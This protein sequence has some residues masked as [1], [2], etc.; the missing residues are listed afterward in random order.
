MTVVTEAL[1]FGPGTQALT[2][3]V[4]SAQG[5]RLGCYKELVMEAAQ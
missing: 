5:R 4:P 1:L 3:S 2:T